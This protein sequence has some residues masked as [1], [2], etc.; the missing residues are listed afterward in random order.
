MSLHSHFQRKD[1]EYSIGIGASVLGEQT[2]LD[3]FPSDLHKALNEKVASE[4]V[5]SSQT[6]NQVL[7]GPL[8]E[9]AKTVSGDD[10]VRI[11]LF[12]E[13]YSTAE[14]LARLGAWVRIFISEKDFQTHYLHGIK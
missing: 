11:R 14:T 10:E 7:F 4:L 9:V 8:V 12:F 5:L 2:G 13:A 3:K 6:G 1:L